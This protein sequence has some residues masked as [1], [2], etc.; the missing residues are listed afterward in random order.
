MAKVKEKENN[1]NN[2][3]M[4]RQWW[5]VCWVYGDQYKMYK[6]M[7]GKKTVIQTLKSQENR[8]E[9]EFQKREVQVVLNSCIEPQ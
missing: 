9:F 7:Y 2:V 3:L 4:C 5:K 8:S 1:A 6:Q